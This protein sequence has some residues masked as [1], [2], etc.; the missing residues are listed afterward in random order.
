MKT[1]C[2]SLCMVMMLAIIGNA[3][4]QD[5]RQITGKVTS[6]QGT[7]LTG[8]TILVKGTA[9][10]TYAKADG[11]Y[12]LMV[13]SDAKT[14]IFKMLGMKTKEV[15]IGQSDEINAVLEEDAMKLNEVVVTAVG[16][17]KEKKAVGYAVQEVGGR[18]LTQSREVN[19]VQSLS[20][21]AAGVQIN[22]S[23]G[24]AGASSNIIIRGA[25]SITGNNSP[26]FVIDGIPIDNSQTF[27]GNPD[28][29]RN[30]LLYGV[31][32]SNRAIDINPEDVAS[33]TIL[34][35][36]AATAL[37]GLRAAGGAII[38][39]TKRGSSSLGDK[40]DI[41]FNTSVGFENVSQ[42]P[43]MQ[44]KYAQ[45]QQVDATGKR[46]RSRWI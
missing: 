36:P 24:V 17:E 44:N 45:G 6:K 26:L 31:A 15:A 23:A 3:T 40:I 29:G 19:L 21:K 18:E 1:F 25:S 11:K 37:Y 39:T 2:T 38:I 41:S 34:K 35:G 33:T 46:F 12:K 16:L 27:S 4:A 14:L 7:P 32:Y 22:S 42:L 5:T 43:P 30:N 10:G 9:I 28:D 20:A 13:P 8:T